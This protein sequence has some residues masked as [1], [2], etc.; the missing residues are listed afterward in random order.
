MRRI[1]SDTAGR[2]TSSRSAI[3]AWMTSTSSSRSSKMA[4]QY[5]SNAG[6][7]SGVW[8]S[9]MVCSVCPGRPGPCGPVIS[10]LKLPVRPC[11]SSRRPPSGSASPP[12]AT[13][14]RLLGLRL[15]PGRGR[16]VDAGGQAS[17][18]PHG[19]EVPSGQDV[20]IVLDNRRRG[21]AQLTSRRPGGPTTELEAGVVQ[22][23]LSVNLPA[24]WV[25]LPVR[26]AP[27]HDRH[28]HRRP[29]ARRRLTATPERWGFR[30]SADR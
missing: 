9:D 23:T 8:Y 12:A 17:V 24:R 20:D 10:G 11:A 7:N 6:W 30:P 2:E 3:R 14:S 22:Q 26:P 1:I 21:P 16:R 25:R 18:R 28:R 13:T 29:A 15:C 4:S 27:G 5:S 19:L